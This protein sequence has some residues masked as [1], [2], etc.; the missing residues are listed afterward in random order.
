MI[1]VE[2]TDTREKLAMLIEL[3][4]YYNRL[5]TLLQREGDLPKQIQDLE[6]QAQALQKQIN[7]KLSD[8]KRMENEISQLHV[9]NDTLL[10]HIQKLEKSLLQLR[11]DEHVFR[12]ET[13]IKEA[14]LTIEK[15]KRDIRILSQKVEVYRGEI[16]EREMQLE[17]LEAMRAEKEARLNEIKKQ[18]AEQRAIVEAQ[19]RRLQRGLAEQD[20]RLYRL[21]ERRIRALREEKALVPVVEVVTDKGEKRVACGG[22]FTLLPRQLEWEIGNRNALYLCE[23]CGRFLV[24]AALFEEMAARVS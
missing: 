16:K 15:N 19:I 10:D 9:S 24:D 5:Y 17:R 8:L 11:S 2:T 7:D 4:V 23:S 12:I 22:C 13:E 18:T 1:T 14:R 20:P 6:Y 3:Q 21:F